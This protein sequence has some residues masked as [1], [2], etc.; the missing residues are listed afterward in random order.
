MVVER[1]EITV[2]LKALRNTLAR[3]LQDS[4]PV[5]DFQSVGD[6]FSRWGSLHRELRSEYP[7]LLD[8]LPFHGM[9]IETVGR[10]SFI[11]RHFLEAVLRDTEYCLDILS[12]VTTVDVPSMTV[13]REGVF[14]AGQYFDALQRVAEILSQ[15][16]KHIAVID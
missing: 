11:R 8:D 13:T 4:R 16:Q 2:R 10:E 3:W 7:S 5:F 1:H 14:F 12:G 6:L 15:A 9:Q